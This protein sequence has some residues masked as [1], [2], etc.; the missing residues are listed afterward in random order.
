M[1]PQNTSS[2]CGSACH[3]NI[4][5]QEQQLSMLIGGGLLASSLLFARS[6]NILT[7]AVGAGL[8]YRG[9]TGHCMTYEALGMS[10]A[11]DD[12]EPARVASSTRP[13]R[14]RQEA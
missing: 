1:A 7:L 12:L 3:R 14:V 9:M 8:L 11:E 13:A 4:S 2:A 5:Q 10:T 6:W